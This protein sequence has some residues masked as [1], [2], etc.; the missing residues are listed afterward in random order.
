MGKLNICVP[1]KREKKWTFVERLLQANYCSSFHEIT[2][3]PDAWNNLLSLI[4]K[5]EA[6]V[7]DL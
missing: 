2:H 7:Y 5:G 1:G 6:R 4:R 3:Q